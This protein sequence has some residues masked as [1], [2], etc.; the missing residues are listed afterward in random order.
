MNYYKNQL[1]QYNDQVE[2]MRKE[3]MLMA[4][5]GNSSIDGSQWLSHMISMAS[6][7]AATLVRE[8]V[9]QISL[10][11]LYTVYSY[12]YFMLVQARGDSKDED[13]LILGFG[14]KKSGATMCTA[15][16]LDFFFG[17]FSLLTNRNYGKL[18]I[19][20]TYI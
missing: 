15:L 3:K 10:N 8:E 4:E 11:L 6:D 9:I 19:Q 20:Y 14:A 13:G 1:E 2:S 7:A 16:G 5:R 18:Y 12:R 17:G